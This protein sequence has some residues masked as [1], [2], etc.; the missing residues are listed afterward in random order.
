[1][2]PN[3]H[4]IL[5]DFFIKGQSLNYIAATYETSWYEVAEILDS[6]PAKKHM[7]SA[8]RVQRLRDVAQNLASRRAAIATLE[9][10]IES[11]RDSSH[12]SIESRRRAADAILRATK[13]QGRTSG[14]VRTPRPNPLPPTSSP[15]TSPS[16]SEK[17]PAPA[18]RESVRKPSNPV[19]QS[20]QVAVNPSQPA[21]VGQPALALQPT[22]ST[23][24]GGNSS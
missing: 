17:Q 7:R 24:C 15:P 18:R 22:N 13:L 14:S 6:E 10:T 2:P 11:R 23:G 9:S 12:S 21:L 20:T 4:S 19:H 8:I 3:F 5:Y 1:M 16:K